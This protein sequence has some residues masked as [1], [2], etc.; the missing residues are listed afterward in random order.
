MAELSRLCSLFPHKFLDIH[1]C[2][3]RGWVDLRATECGK[4]EQVT[5]K[6]SEDPTGN[7]TWHLLY[8]QRKI[9]LWNEWHFVENKMV[10]MQRTLM[11]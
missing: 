10:I 11:Q 8:E 5:W 2:S 3:F 9:K 4:K 6:I 1:F 7:Q